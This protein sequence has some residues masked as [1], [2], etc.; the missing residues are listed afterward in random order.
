LNFHNVRSI[1]NPPDQ[2]WTSVN[3]SVCA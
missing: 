1:N 2:F 3:H